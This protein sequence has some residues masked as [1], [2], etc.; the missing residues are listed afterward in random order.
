MYKKIIFSLF[1]VFLLL[2]SGCSVQDSNSNE[3]SQMVK[4]VWIAYYELS[5]FTNGKS[6]KEFKSNMSNA[7]KTLSQKGFNR[8]TVQVRPFADAFYKSSYFPVSAYCFGVQ[9]SSLEYD[10]LEIMTELAHKYNLEIE[11]WINPYRV[12]N[13][14]DFSRL[15]KDNIANKW[16]DTENLIVCDSG[17]YFNPAS[18]KVNK[19]IV[20]GVKEI[21]ENYDVD[22]VCFDD[23]F[24]PDTAE[25]IDKSS[26]ENYRKNGGKLSLD[27]WRRDNVSSLVKEVYKAVK[28]VDEGVTFGISPG[29]NIENDYNSLYADVELW[30][31]EKGYV[32]YICPQIYFGFQNENQ[33][34]MKTAKDWSQM[35]ECDF[36][37]ALPLYKANTED[38]FAGESGKNEFVENNNITARQFTYLTKLPNTK[39]I[40]I[41]S[42][43]CLCDNDE[44]KNLYSAMQKSSQ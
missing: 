19:L 26:Y 14:N 41:F 27:D 13:S 31:S 9:G 15:S 12:S 5:E 23:Y 1:I 21:V 11:A 6:E 36:Y 32:D 37:A 4:S 29:G 38:E 28:E 30:C 16:K 18:S 35:A 42:Y 22:S 24:Y 43:S 44:T 7:L 10:V 20:N 34:F 25:S 8:I 3:K 2:L 33:P 40:Y 17:I 39:G